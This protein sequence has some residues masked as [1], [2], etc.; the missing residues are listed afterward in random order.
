MDQELLQILDALGE[1]IAI[2]TDD[3]I[4]WCTSDAQQLGLAAGMPIASLF[5]QDITADVLVRTRQLTLPRL[6]TQLYA[7]AFPLGK[8]FLLVFREDA[9]AFDTAAFAQTARMLRTPLNGILSVSR[10]L[11]ERL[12]ELEDPDI[13]AQTAK[14][15]RGFYQILRTANALSD[16][17]SGL[18]QDSFTPRRVELCAWLES[19]MPQACSAAAAAGRTLEIKSPSR[20]F[21]GVIDPPLLEQ[22]LWCLLSNAIRYSPPHSTISLSLQEHN[23]QCL[24]AL[25]NCVL[26]PVSLD[27]LTTGFQ[28][29]LRVEAAEHGLGLGILRAQHIVTQHEGVMLLEC[30]PKGEFVVRIRLPGRLSPENLHTTLL[31]PDRSGGYSR[32]LIELS[33]ILPDEAYDS[34]NL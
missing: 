12:E 23:G 1:S 6:G 21:Y 2:V 14:L 10:R 28:R 24:I 8:G 15:N 26:Q 27:A 31:P 19:F 4:T 11:F 30:T 29:P 16:L 20:C 34:R 3:C 33:D 17:Q 13:Q 9:A 22:A 18:A 5:S 32:L 25:R 7:R